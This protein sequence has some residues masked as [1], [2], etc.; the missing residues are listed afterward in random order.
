MEEY[1]RH[2]H[3]LE[4]STPRSSSSTANVHMILIIG[5]FQKVHRLFH[6]ANP[7]PL[8]LI[9]I[10]L[11]IHTHHILIR[12]ILDIAPRHIQP[13]ILGLQLGPRRP[14]NALPSR[15]QFFVHLQHPL[16][17]GNSS[18]SLILTLPCLFLLELPQLRFDIQ[19]KVRSTQVGHHLRQE[20]A[21]GGP[22]QHLGNEIVPR[23]TD[24]RPKDQSVRRI[25]RIPL[26]I[27]LAH[28]PL[29]RPLL[30]TSQM[31]LLRHG[32]GNRA[33]DLGQLEHA[34]E[35]QHGREF[36][37]YATLLGPARETKVGI[38]FHLGIIHGGDGYH[39]LGRV[40]GESFREHDA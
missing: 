35:L 32:H 11:I 20:S 24:A 25:L 4:G 21:I 10:R 6:R 19:F 23:L 29:L 27:L 22:P 15:D 1:S 34:P 8:Q 14:N 7:I 33:G 28:H 9:I 30:K 26:L 17:R 12:R 39:E 2:G 40:G 18:F 38:K 16:N 3:F 37:G 31:I 36:F 5:K 13:I